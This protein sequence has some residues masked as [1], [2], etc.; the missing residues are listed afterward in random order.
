MFTLKPESVRIMRAAL[1]V[2]TKI[3]KP[4]TILPAQPGATARPERRTASPGRWR[5]LVR[6]FDPSVN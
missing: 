2:T 3:G 4:E 6:L 5:G 1:G